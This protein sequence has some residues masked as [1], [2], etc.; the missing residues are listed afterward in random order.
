MRDECRALIQTTAC[1]AMEGLV[2]VRE[3]EDTQE[4]CVKER[5]DKAE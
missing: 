1:G 3:R 5:I 2:E 4:V